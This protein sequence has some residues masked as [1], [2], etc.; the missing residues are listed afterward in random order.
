MTGTAELDLARLTSAALT[1]AREAAQLVLEGHRSRPAVQRKASYADLVTQYD[2][3]SER[4]IRRRLAELTPEIAIVG[5]EEGGD[6]GDAPTWLCDPIDGTVNF[7]H[8]HPFFCVSIG[9][10][11]RGVPLAGAVVAP[12]LSLEWH[13]FAGGGAFRNGQPCS[14][15]EPDGLADA[16][17]ATGISPVMRRHG[18]PEDNLAAF[19]RVTPTVRDIRRCG[20]AAIDLTFVADGTYDAYWERRLAPWDMAAGAALVLAA[21]GRI[22][23][24]QGGA[25]DLTRG[26]VL[27][28]NG[29]VHDALL[30]LLRPE[31]EPTQV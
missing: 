27:A 19:N 13:G 16:L 2:L 4:V 29:H 23:N 3:Q 8:G 6:V 21:G 17:V 1:V 26:Y 9:L 25:Y 12:A 30:E 15:A 5:E 10:L 18:H 22:T 24:L 14:V 11:H 28:S 31:A 20:S 7:A